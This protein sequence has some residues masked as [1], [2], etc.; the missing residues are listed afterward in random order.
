MLDGRAN[1][2]RRRVRSR[3]HVADCCKTVAREG[4]NGA[5]GNG[6]HTMSDIQGFK[7]RA[8]AGKLLAERLRAYAP[9]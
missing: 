9:H 7:N 1:G 2:P 4:Q 6:L 5:V 8:Q 3:T